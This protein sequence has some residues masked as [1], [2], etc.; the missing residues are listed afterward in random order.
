MLAVVAEIGRL[1]TTGGFNEYQKTCV[2]CQRDRRVT[3]ESHRLNKGR[4]QM[5]TRLG[6][7]YVWSS[8]RDYGL[9]DVFDDV[10][11]STCLGP[12]CDGMVCQCCSRYEEERKPMDAEQ[13]QDCEAAP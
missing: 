11:C 12:S 2:R 1:Q 9:E 7:V 5:K 10:L 6:R 3:L 4:W 8:C 13:A